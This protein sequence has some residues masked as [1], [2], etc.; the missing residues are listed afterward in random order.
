MNTIESIEARLAGLFSS[1]IGLTLTDAQPDRAAAQKLIRPNKCTA[2]GILHG[3]AI[4]AFADTLGAV[5]TVLNMPAGAGTA[6][7]EWEANFFRPALT[8]TTVTGTTTPVNRGKRTQ[9][10]ETRITTEDGKLVALVTQTQMV[11]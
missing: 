11:F 6:T 7:I 10:W 2:G 8:G 4:M 1:L 9:T 5:G 3:G